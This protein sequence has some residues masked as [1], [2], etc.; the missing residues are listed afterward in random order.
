MLRL[1]IVLLL[2]TLALVG[3]GDESNRAPDD[4]LQLLTDSAEKIR[5]AN[6]FRLYV[7]QSGA[8]MYFH[9]YQDEAQTQLIEIEYRFAHAQYVAPD[10]LQAAAR[11]IV[12]P[13]GLP[14]DAEIF[15]R[16]TDQW[17]RLP[18]IL[19]NWVRGDFAPGFNP[20]TLIADDSGFQA[21]LTSLKALEWVEST[22]LDDGQPVHH[23]RGIADGPS[24]S[25]LVVGLIEPT[26]DVPVDVFVNRDTGYPVRL[27]LKQPETITDDNPE[28]TTWT[29]DVYD[30]N[31]EPALTP[32]SDTDADSTDAETSPTAEAETSEEVVDEITPPAGGSDNAGN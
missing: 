13:V 7:E 6:T 12:R 32:P 26:G 28:P 3:C 30:I 16:A 23:L 21:A 25:A 15:S 17:Y 9:I 22:T 24:V 2:I 20:A 4:P 19:N 31:A 27:I 29:I 18:P 14:V 11:I 1:L 8:P 5:S 10:S